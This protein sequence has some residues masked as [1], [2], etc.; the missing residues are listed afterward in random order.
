MR[1][2]EIFSTRHDFICFYYVVC[3]LVNL[4]EPLP[5]SGKNFMSGTEFLESS[6]DSLTYK[7][8]GLS[9][10]AVKSLVVVKSEK[11][12]SG[13]GVDKKTLSL[14]HALFSGM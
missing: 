13:T 11:V 12:S 5:R 9:L 1:F 7:E 14:I 2:T 4:F 6:R 10:S 8:T 3:F